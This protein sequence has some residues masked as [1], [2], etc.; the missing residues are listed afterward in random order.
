MDLIGSLRAARRIDNFYLE[1]RFKVS[2]TNNLI[3]IVTI[4]K[5]RSFKMDILIPCA[6]PDLWILR[7]IPCNFVGL[8]AAGEIS[9]ICIGLP[10]A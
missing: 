8:Q 10:A 1:P 2:I 4:L 5:F 7:R 9:N 3:K 6:D